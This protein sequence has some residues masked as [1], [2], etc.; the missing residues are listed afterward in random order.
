R[1]TAAQ[2]PVKPYFTLTIFP[3]AKNSPDSFGNP[4]DV[5]HNHRQHAERTDGVT[6]AAPGA[7]RHQRN[8]ACKRTDD[9][10]YGRDIDSPVPD[11]AGIGTFVKI[12]EL[13][14]ES[15]TLFFHLA[16]A[17]DPVDGHRSA[18]ARNGKG[19]LDLIGIVLVVRR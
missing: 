13:S 10:Q 4:D 14:K 17:I 7:K 5:N 18:S 12:A 2:R 16:S 19:H 3:L 15:A 11:V 8:H 6:G 9:E 1:P